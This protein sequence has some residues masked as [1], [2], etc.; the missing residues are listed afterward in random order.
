MLRVFD[1]LFNPD[2]EQLCEVLTLDGGRDAR[3]RAKQGPPDPVDS[4]DVNAV[5]TINGVVYFFKEDDLVQ[6]KCITSFDLETEEWGATFEGPTLTFV[7]N[8]LG[9]PN[10][11]VRCNRLTCRPE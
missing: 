6:Q 10:N 2:S 1:T 5:T 3:W 7:A 9:L 11:H 8:D 4:F